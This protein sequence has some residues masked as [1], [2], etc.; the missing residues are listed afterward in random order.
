MLKY[1]IKTSVNKFDNSD[2]L[3]FY[4]RLIPVQ[5][6]GLEE[7]AEEISKHNTLTRADIKGALTALEHFIV[8]HIQNGQSVRFGDL[9]SFR[10]TLKGKT[11]ATREELL[12]SK[13][14]KVMVRF[15]PSSK[16]KEMFR[17]ENNEIQLYTAPK[18]KGDAEGDTQ[19]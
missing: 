19:E 8:K 6:V 12:K 7:I 15:T 4:K 17:L 3:V 11:F 13:D 9:G 5:P 10:P 14:F 18:V 1:T 2:N 16:M